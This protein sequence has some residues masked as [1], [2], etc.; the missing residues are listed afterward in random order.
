MAGV[1]AQNS[2]LSEAADWLIRLRYETPTAKEQARFEQWRSQSPA[3]EAAWH[4]AEAMLGVF[5]QVPAE[6]C[7]QTLTAVQRP[8]RRKSLAWLGSLLVAAPAGWLVW[9]E[10]SWRDWMADQAT[11]VGQSRSLLLPDGSTLTLNTASAVAIRFNAQ[12]RRV[13][14][15]GGEILVTTHAD[16][17][18]RYRPFV[19]ETRQGTVQALGT[20]FSVRRVDADTSRVAVFSHTVAIT[21][22][23][24]A[25]Q[26]LQEGHT[27]DFSSSGIGPQSDVQASAALWEQ[28]ML[29]A[30]DMPLADVVAEIARYRTGRLH[31]DPAVAQLR[32][33]GALSLKDTD[34]SLALLA[35]SLPVRIEREAHG[36][37]RV[38]G[39]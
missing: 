6:V 29:L 32:L 26:L 1:A 28:G 15:L 10:L 13:R 33:S 37:V 11:A 14:L 24:G 39:R 7:Q 4:K 8:D 9:R 25:T 20:R 23:Q 19:V 30:K 31:C 38:V 36:V 12:E 18:P 5:A 3:H 34:A 27:S 21:N 2:L 17:S 16:P 35:Q 22:Q